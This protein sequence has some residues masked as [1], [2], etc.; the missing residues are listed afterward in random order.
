MIV[1]NYHS[2]AWALF[3][4][5]KEVKKETQIS[6]QAQTIIEALTA[7]EEIIAI[8]NSRKLTLQEIEEIT[9]AAFKGIHQ[10]LINFI[11][12]VAQKSRANYI[13]PV[14]RKL[15]TLINEYLGIK[16]GIVYSTF[17]LTKAQIAGIETKVAQQLGQKPTLINKLDPQLMS[18]FKIIIEDE[19][20]EDSILS[21]IHNLK[22]SLLKG[23]K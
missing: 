13:V 20:I 11:N 12:I 19:V 6:K 8:F 4:L 7:N 3:A 10:Y 9:S 18:G 22:H 2:Y 14:L 21:R 15:I 17:A 16:Q 5:A 1:K 23:G